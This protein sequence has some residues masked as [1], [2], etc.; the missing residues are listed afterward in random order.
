MD[1]HKLALKFVDWKFMLPDYVLILLFLLCFTF[2]LF[3]IFYIVCLLEWDDNSFTNR[4]W[5]WSQVY[6]LLLADMWNIL[7][8]ISDRSADVTFFIFIIY[9]RMIC[10]PFRNLKGKLIKAIITNYFIIH[11]FRKYIISYNLTKKEVHENKEKNFKIEKWMESSQI[12]ISCMFVWLFIANKNVLL[13]VFKTQTKINK[14]KSLFPSQL[15]EQI[16]KK[17]CFSSIQV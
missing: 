13:S 17:K 7:C 14:Q 4:K 2:I 11:H 6:C 3:F 12:A 5:V 9:G 16:R 8:R 15:Y 10:R 1:Y